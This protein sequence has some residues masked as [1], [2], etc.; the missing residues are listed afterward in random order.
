MVGN[1]EDV[2]ACNISSNTFEVFLQYY[3]EKNLSD[4][5]SITVFIYNYMYMYQKILDIIN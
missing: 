5:Y 2:M 4:I 3:L 1:D